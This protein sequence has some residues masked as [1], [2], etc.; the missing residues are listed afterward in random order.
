MHQVLAGLDLQSLHQLN[1]K[2]GDS[3]D[4]VNPPK[5]LSYEEWL[6]KNIRRALDA[7]LLDSGPRKRILDLGCGPCW[8][9]LVARK[10]HHNA[11]G[12]DVPGHP[13]YP[14][15]AELLGFKPSP[16][17]I[18]PFDPLP[19][20]LQSFD[21]ITAHMTCFNRHGKHRP[22]G[23][24]EWGYFLDD[25]LPRLQ[26]G[27]RMILELN[28]LPDGRFMPDDVRALFQQ[29]GGRVVRS[30]ATFRQD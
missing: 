5:Y 21:L 28:P 6:P 17:R 3:D 24:S 10:L 29:R 13:F 7:G 4:R 22:W 11:L 18:R 19:A 8:F 1:L 15:V 16:H 2:W 12:I 23:A 26:T 30:R 27:G 25:L 20:S 14:E 9:L